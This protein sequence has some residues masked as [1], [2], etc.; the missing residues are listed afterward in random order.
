MNNT[1]WYKWQD[2]NKILDK[3]QP[4]IY[5]IAYSEK[6]ISNEQ[7]SFLEEIIYIGMTI[8]ANGLQG[9]LNQFES[10]MKGKDNLHGGAERVRY[11]HKDHESFF[12]KTYVSARIFNLSQTRETA[13]DWRIKADCVGHEYKSFAEYLDKFNHLP[14]FN[15]QKISK[16]K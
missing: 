14:E 2:R 6:D 13:N 11:K 4:A 1:V 8:S 16:K 12:A 9:R 10:A 3:N 15:D 7:F 5:Y